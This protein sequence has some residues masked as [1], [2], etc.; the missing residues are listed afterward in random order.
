MLASVYFVA[1]RLGLE[2]A[3]VHPSATF[4]WAPSGIALAFCLIAGTWV[5]PAILVAAF[6]VNVTTEATV[7]ASLPIAVG[8][9]LEPVLAAYLVTRFANGSRSFETVRDAAY[10]I[11]FA[12]GVSPV[13]AATMGVT[14]LT[15]GGLATWAEFG[16]IWLAWW[17]GD[18]GGALVVAPV[19]LLWIYPPPMI[20][21]R[22]KIVEASA[23]SAATAVASVAVFGGVLPPTMQN[24]PMDF[25]CVP[26]VGWAALR[27]SPRLA[28]TQMFLVSAVAVWGTVSGFG[29][30][31]GE[32][33]EVAMLLLNA[34]IGITGVGTLLFAATV[35]ERRKLVQR[36]R[37]LSLSDPMTGLANYRRLADVL[38]S[39][40]E[41]SQRT[42]HPFAVLLFDLDG[43]KSVNDRYG[44]LAGDRALCRLADTLRATCRSVDTPARYG[45][46][47]FV[48]VL[49]ETD[50][51]AAMTV[52]E[53]VEH[54]LARDREKP[55]ISVSVGCAVYPED[56]TTIQSLIAKADTRLYE[57]KP[58]PR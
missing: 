21:T 49:P 36:L 15:L 24:Y 25:V 12:A 42:E 40:I 46:D 1:G 27:L 5:W 53:R 10:Y 57:R 32:P 20:W 23:T 37:E 7:G 43:L 56:G 17:A 44:H 3:V 16:S 33:P 4:V 51:A 45:G 41:R 11:L 50:R 39:E 14:S 58:G 26:F 18:A 29:P 35:R 28:A 38:E 22:A 9:T 8:N 6:A 2:M 19:I 30:F 55:P 48:L 52:G 47:E 34:Y 54:E 13:V 31:A